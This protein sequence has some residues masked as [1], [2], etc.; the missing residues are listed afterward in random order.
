MSAKK[1]AKIIGSKKKKKAASPGSTRNK[2]DDVGEFMR[3]LEHPLKS[4]L[5]VVRGIILGA[6]PQIREDIKW[7]APSFYVNEYF[8]TINVRGVSGRDCILIIL[9]RG[10]RVKDNSSEGLEIKDPAGLLEWLASDRCAIKFYDMSDVNSK[11]AALED[12]VRQ[13]IK[14]M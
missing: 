13:W 8:A 14:G 4:E 9:H 10:A 7:N 2:T 1:K 6:D 3:K 12:I 5:E 11:K